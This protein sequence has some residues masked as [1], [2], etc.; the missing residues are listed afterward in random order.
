MRS[1]LWPLSVGGEA[2]TKKAWLP[3]TRRKVL[4][5]TSAAA[6]L[7]C[8]P[9]FSR[10]A[11]SEGVL[12]TD[13]GT[14]PDGFAPEFQEVPPGLTTSHRVAQ[15]YR[16]QR[17]VSW[18]DAVKPGG[19]F[20]LGQLTPAEQARRVGYNCDYTAFMP[21][22]YGSAQS[23]HG[24]LHINHEYTNAELMFPS[25]PSDEKATGRTEEQMSIEQEAHGFSVIE[26][27]RSPRSGDWERVIGGY[28][29]RRVTATTPILISGPAAGDARMR[30]AEDPEGKVVLGTIGNCA[31]GV[32]PWGT[33]LVA[34]ENFDVYFSG[35]QDDG[36]QAH[37]DRYTVAK[38]TLYGWH[39]FDERFDVLQTPNEPN[40]FGWV[41]E[42][43][44]YD[45]T[46][47]PVKRTALGRFKHES[48]TC[49]LSADGRLVAY[50]GDDEYFEYI[51]R[52]VSRD[53]VNVTDRSANKDLLDHGVLSVAIFHDDGVLQW[54]P[55]VWGEWGLTPENGFHSQADVLIETRRAADIVGA[56]KMDRP[57]GIAVHPY[58]GE[59]YVSLT[60]NPKREETNAANPRAH[61]RAGHI[62][63]LK[64]S[65]TDA[66]VQHTEDAFSWEIFVLAGDPDSDEPRYGGR[67]STKGW[68]G[69]PD[70]LAF[71]KAGILWVATDGMQGPYQRANGL[72]SLPTDG[73]RSAVPKAFFRAP[74][75]AEVTGPSFTPDGQTLFLSIQHPAEET[76][77]EAPSTRWPDFRSDIP[78]RP[79]VIAISREK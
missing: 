32:T 71:D 30:T 45:P 1:R 60:K 48:A 61:N 26:I 10:A 41:V 77:F 3:I 21:Y 50:S 40:R 33:V 76:S 78:P 54:V 47:Q 5:S 17:L 24:L 42:Y 34:E 64:P 62:V 68:F 56:T 51:Y 14:L 35:K 44:P 38:E 13:R 7:S 59:V 36:Q 27:K 4:A 75:G 63:K 25:A 69:C 6:L 43:D 11:E 23:N 74:V 9:R 58:T 31:G 18:G 15:G 72:F 12:P 70:N 53:K 65:R 79:T 37:R 39:R 2:M 28:C 73:E 55:L 46:A 49:V 19:L 52:F 67:P 8:L 66:G 29:N 20:D 57:E 22:P 16:V